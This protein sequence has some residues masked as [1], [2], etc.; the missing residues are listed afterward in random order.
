MKTVVNR[1]HEPIHVA[2]GGGR[3]LHLEPNGRGQV[4]D[5]R[6][7]SRSLRALL[8]AGRIEILAAGRPQPIRPAAN[9]GAGTQTHGHHP[10]VSGKRRGNR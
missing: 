4:A 9:R 6:A 5:S 3:V 7:D 8:E 2:L 1:T 10:P